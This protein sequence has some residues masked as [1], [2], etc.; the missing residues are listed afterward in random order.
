MLHHTFVNFPEYF[1]V[2]HR[3]RKEDYSAEHWFDF[4]MKTLFID[5]NVSPFVKTFPVS[6]HNLSFFLWR[7]KKNINTCTFW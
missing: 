3:S 5:A 6:T 4:S 1:I 7:N 2:T